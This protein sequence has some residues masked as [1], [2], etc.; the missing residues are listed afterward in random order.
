MPK[1]TNE[2]LYV[3]FL[4]RKN[5]TKGASKWQQPKIR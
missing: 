1:I 5:K 4:F 3:A 2:M